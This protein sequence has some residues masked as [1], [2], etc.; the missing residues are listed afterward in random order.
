MISLDVDE[1]GEFVRPNANR[2]GLSL[3]IGLSRGYVPLDNSDWW[4]VPQDKNEV[5]GLILV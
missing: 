3:N 1:N 2:M 5:W 4:K